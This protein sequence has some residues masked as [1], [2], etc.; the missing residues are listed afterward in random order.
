M[1]RKNI[2]NYIILPMISILIYGCSFSNPRPQN[3]AKAQDKLLAMESYMCLAK[4]THIDGDKRNTYE[5]KQAYC[6]DGKYRV[7]VTKPQHIAGVV[8]VFDGEKILQYNPN[9]SGTQILE[10]QPNSFRNQTFLGTFLHNYLQSEEVTLEVQNIDQETAVVL[11]A[12]IPGGS[13]YMATQKLW[14][15]GNT[16]KPARMVIYDQED[17]ETVIIEF[18]KFTYNPEIQKDIFTMEKL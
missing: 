18:L 8:T 12:I 17:Q 11:E 7:E 6:I 2:I 1:Y 15:D 3:P 9:T 4:I 16:N 5:S 13:V 14:I 10:L